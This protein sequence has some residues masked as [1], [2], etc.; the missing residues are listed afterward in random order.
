MTRLADAVA[1]AVCVFAPQLGGEAVVLLAVDCHP[2]HGAVALAILTTSD[3]TPDRLLA[4]PAEMAAWRHY[5][6][7][8]ELPSWQPVARLGR[9]MQAAYEAG[10]RP[11][12]AEA[13]LRSC[14]AAV[15]S[16]QVGA[17]LKLLNRTGEFR[18]SVTHPDNGHEFVPAG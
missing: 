18:V 4:D 9:E 15:S 2:W 7:A 10:D 1:A 14:A 17:S 3:V 8:R 6:F 5:D 12:V 11:I 13:F 16:A